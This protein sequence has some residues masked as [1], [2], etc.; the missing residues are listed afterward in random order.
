MES[1][2]PPWVM[3]N[4]TLTAMRMRMIPGEIL[5]IPHPKVSNISL[6]FIPAMTDAPNPRSGTTGDKGKG[7]IRYQGNK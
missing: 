6:N 7:K 1:M 4:F 2:I 3:M 5:A